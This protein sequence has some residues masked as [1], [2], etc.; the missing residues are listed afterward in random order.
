MPK[1]KNNNEKR[2]S[3][4]LL[5]KLRDHTHVSANKGPVSLDLCILVQNHIKAFYSQTALKI[6]VTL[7][8]KQLAIIHIQ[9]FHIELNSM[10]IYI[11]FSI[12]SQI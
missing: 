3:T 5:C 7:I 6:A 4:N 2:Q 1:E 9:M 11:E 10:F 8:Q 12:K